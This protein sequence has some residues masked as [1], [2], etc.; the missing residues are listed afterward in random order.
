MRRRRRPLRSAARGR[1]AT[2]RGACVACMVSSGYCEQNP[3]P[4]VNGTFSSCA[5]PTCVDRTSGTPAVRF[6]PQGTP[7]GA[8]FDVCDGAGSC[9]QFQCVGQP[10]GACCAVTGP[11]G[12]G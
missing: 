6:K 9:G 12:C 8:D 2:P 7:C 1:S 11:T 3:N 10:D 4:C 5:P